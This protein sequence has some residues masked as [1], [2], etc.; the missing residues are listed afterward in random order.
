MSL[1]LPLLISCLIIVITL[2]ILP[3]VVSYKAEKKE[4]ANEWK[5]I[6]EYSDKINKKKRK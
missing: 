1:S 5:K 3:L 4:E 2:I 6:K